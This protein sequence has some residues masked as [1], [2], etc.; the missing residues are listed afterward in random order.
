MAE[1]REGNLNFEP[2]VNPEH[3]DIYQGIRDGRLTAQQLSRL[4]DRDDL[5][6]EY[7]IRLGGFERRL[8]EY[9]DNEV[10]GTLLSIDLDDFKR[11]NDTQ[12]HP[13]GNDLIRLAAKILFEQTRS[14]PPTPEIADRRQ[15][16]RQELDL[17][18]RG[19]DEFLVFL[20]GAQIPSALS[21]AIR[22]R[23]SIVNEVRQQFPNYGSE[24]TMSL[25]LAYPKNGE[26]ASILYQRSDQALYRAKQGKYT[27]RVRDSI[28]VAR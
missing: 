3:L 12:G 27:G 10:T 14:R 9:L 17:L 1:D 20:V 22:I 2:Q 15:Y 18:G 24:Q 13:A 26:T 23:R 8:G 6:P 19:G 21:A 16:R 25:G 28:V 4:L 7:L 11:F 5:V